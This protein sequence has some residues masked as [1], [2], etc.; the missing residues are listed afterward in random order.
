MVLLSLKFNF[1]KEEKMRKYLFF[2][3]VSLLLSRQPVSAQ[4]LSGETEVGTDGKGESFFSQYLFYDIEHVN[5]LARYFW[6]NGVLQRGE[7]AIGPTLKLN[8]GN[9]LK[10]Q[11]G[12]TTDE[13][14]MIAGLLIAKVRGREVLYIAD[15]KLSTQDG[16]HVLYQKLFV[17]LTKGGAWQLRT[18]HLQVGSNQSFL[19]IGPEYLRNLPGSAHVFIGPYYDPIRKGVGGQVGIRFF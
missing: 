2:V 15:A 9:V 14:I 17:P 1:R 10:L 19:R 8:S 18:E 7:F 4:N 12:G 6:V 5:V 11:F 16:P 13:E 3:I